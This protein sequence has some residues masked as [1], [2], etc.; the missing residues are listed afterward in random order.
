[1]APGGEFPLPGSL[2][3]VLG[4]QIATRGT[5]GEQTIDNARDFA[6]GGH[7]GLAAA[8]M[9]KL[10]VREIDGPQGF[11]KHPFPSSIADEPAADFVAN[12]DERHIGFMRGEGFDLVQE[13][14]QRLVDEAVDG[15]FPGLGLSVG[16]KRLIEMV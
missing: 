10:T 4:T 7:D 6:G 14:L 3:T 9:Q 5:V 1:V 13:E 2:F 11:E 16:S 12:A 8:A 15:E